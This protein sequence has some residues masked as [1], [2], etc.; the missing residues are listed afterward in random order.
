MGLMTIA[1]DLFKHCKDYIFTDTL[2]YKYITDHINMLR[3]KLEDLL[4]FLVLMR[5]APWIS[6][7]P[8]R[9]LS[10]HPLRILG[11]WSLQHTPKKG[12]SGPKILKMQSKLSYTCPVPVHAKK[13]C[14]KVCKIHVYL[15]IWFWGQGFQK[16]N[17]KICKLTSV[18]F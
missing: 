8:S 1:T 16:C 18:L 17:E 2:G 6:F 4:L 10:L 7:Y 11:L 5:L 9:I 15:F 12:F 3:I 13:N 14:K